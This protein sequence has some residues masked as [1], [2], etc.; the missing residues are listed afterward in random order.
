VTI[1]FFDQIPR[2]TNFFSHP[3]EWFLIFYDLKVNP[4]FLKIFEDKIQRIR[5]IHDFSQKKRVR[6][7]EFGSMVDFKH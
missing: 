2:H 7:A 5:F 6:N 4:I 3:L 1:S